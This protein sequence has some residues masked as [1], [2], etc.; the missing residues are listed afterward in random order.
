MGIMSH[1][2]NQLLIENSIAVTLSLFLPATC[3]F[4][5]K[6]EEDLQDNGYTCRWRQVDRQT[7]R[8]TVFADVY[9]RTYVRDNESRL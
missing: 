8:R 6:G 3:I 2:I 4:G 5:G 9:I 7:D 1:A